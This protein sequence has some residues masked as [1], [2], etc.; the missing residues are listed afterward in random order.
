MQNKLTEI[1]VDK[2]A[3]TEIEDCILPKNLTEIFLGIQKKEVIPNMILSGTAGNGKT[4]IAKLLC[5]KLGIDYK[6]INASNK[7]NIDL[8]RTD[9]EDYASS[10]SMDGKRKI[11]ILDE[12]D[13]L[14]E[15]TQLALRNQI[16]YFSDICGFIMTCNRPYQILSL[17][18]I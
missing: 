7:R 3:P 18:H 6:V 9:I 4:T 16:E 14:T 13:Q 12:A 5:K 10:L 8:V 17:I 2:Y 11:I 1:W 15:I